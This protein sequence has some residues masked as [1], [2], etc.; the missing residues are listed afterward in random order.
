[1]TLYFEVDDP[2][3]TLEWIAASDLPY[4]RWSRQEILKLWPVQS[5]G[6]GFMRGQAAFEWN[7]CRPAPMSLLDSQVRVDART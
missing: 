1:M 4:D 3:R 6:L 5:L 7:S 2:D